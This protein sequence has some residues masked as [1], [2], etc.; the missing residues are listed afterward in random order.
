MPGP[1]KHPLCRCS[2]FFLAAALTVRLMVSAASAQELPLE[3]PRADGVLLLR[4]GNVL[5]GR[6]TQ[7]GESYEVVVDGGRIRVKASDVEFCCPTLEEG[8]RRKRSLVQPGDVRAH[9]EL[10]EWCQRHDLFA[11]AARELAQARA[12]QP[13]HPLIPVVERRIRTSLCQPER[14][15]RPIERDAKEATLPPSSDELDLMVRGMPPG[16]VETFTQTIQPVLVNHC[17]TAGCHG[18]GTESRF[19]LLRTPS[20]RPASRR[21]TQRN[22][23]STLEWI[24]RDVPAAS[25]LLTAPLHPHG[26]AQAAVFTDQQVEQYQQLVNWVNQVARSEEPVA[27]AAQHS[28]LEAPRPDT[29]PW[30]ARPAV[31]IESVDPAGDDLPRGGLDASGP[32][33]PGTIS[34]ATIK[35]RASMPR[36]VPVDPFD[37]AIFNRRFFPE[38]QSQAH[39]EVAPRE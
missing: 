13:R 15:E 31:H 10:A 37:P 27:G 7:V 3:P 12:V 1:I 35:P 32:A 5:E 20:G 34:R 17:S 11:A 24:D 4:N 25:R 36:F 29:R 14:I 26:S 2:G 18:P 30:P 21:L 23:H 33:R 28:K 39:G 22:L 8:Y 6:I 38:G 9:L 19:R 16:S